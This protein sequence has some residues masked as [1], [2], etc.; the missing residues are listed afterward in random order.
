LDRL[1]VSGLFGVKNL[2]LWARSEIDGFAF[3]IMHAKA[4][5]DQPSAFRKNL[6]GDAIQIM[7]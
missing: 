2:I 6:D 3:R 5:S 1:D 4:I 7:G